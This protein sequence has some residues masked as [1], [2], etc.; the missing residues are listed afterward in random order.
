MK[1]RISILLA[2]ILLLVGIIPTA[3]AA[4]NEDDIFHYYYYI[5][6]VQEQNGT[7]VLRGV[8]VNFSEKRHLVGLENVALDIYNVDDEKICSV[9]VDEDFQKDFRLRP[10]GILAY[11]AE[12]SELTAK[13]K[14]A[15]LEEEIFGILV[16]GTVFYGECSGEKCTR[17]GYNGLS[18]SEDPYSDTA[19]Q[20]KDQC[21]DCNGIGSYTC[22]YCDGDYDCPDCVE[23]RRE[24][25]ETEIEKLPCST[26]KGSGVCYSCDGSGTRASTYSGKARQCSRCKG[27]GICSGCK[28][29]GVNPYSG[30]YEKTQRIVKAICETCDGSGTQCIH[31]DSGI[32]TCQTCRGTGKSATAQTS[33][34]PAKNSAGKGGA[35]GNCPTCAGSGFCTG[36]DGLGT[37]SNYNCILGKVDCSSCY[38]TGD[39][40]VCYGLGSSLGTR[41]SR[42]F[43]DGDCS[44]CNGVGEFKCSSC[45][46]TGNCKTCGGSLWCKTCGGDGNV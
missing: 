1:R 28:G 16:G 3:Y 24:V 13:Q 2:V 41:C 26:C 37:C 43:G 25:S 17:C 7:M 8:F 42:C 30:S 38:G 39:C 36:C 23:G 46:G 31:C 20:D 19:T 12:T 21:A 33:Q 5:K 18:M 32:I 9:T 14:K 22:T 6:D 34:T 45:N 35:A 4:D 10:Q 44:R 40:G 15:L 27:K 29:S 11:M